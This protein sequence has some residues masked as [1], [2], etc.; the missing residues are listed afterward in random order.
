MQRAC[1]AGHRRQ[2]SAAVGQQLLAAVG[3]GDPFQLAG[4]AE[5]QQ[6]LS[7][8]TPFRRSQ[9]RQLMAKNRALPAALA[10]NRQTRRCV[11]HGFRCHQNINRM[12]QNSIPL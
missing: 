8:R 10:E 11:S 3:V 1:P 2:L 6:L 7:C 4:K 12:A 9:L 5:M